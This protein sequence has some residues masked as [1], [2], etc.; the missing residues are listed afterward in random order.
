MSRQAIET[1]NGKQ[2]R[3]MLL[4]RIL[5][6][7]RTTVGA[8][9]RPRRRRLLLSV[10]LNITT[11]LF[12][13][14]GVGAVLPLVALLAIPD[15]FARYPMLAAWVPEHLQRDRAALVV[16]GAGLFALIYLLRA[17]S[18]LASATV[19]ARLQ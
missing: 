5:D 14:I 8:A 15:L 16:A 11:A 17:V 9:G 10:A 18:S 1:G 7:L 13:A 19:V 3:S 4:P 6:D 12:D 2:K